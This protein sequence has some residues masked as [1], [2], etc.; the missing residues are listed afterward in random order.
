VLKVSVWRGG[1]N[2]A[3]Q[4]FEVPREASQ[5]ILDVVTHIQRAL[6]PTL[7][8]CFACRVGMCGSCAMTVNGVPRWPCRTHVDKVAEGDAFDRLVDEPAFRR[9]RL[10]ARELVPA[11]VGPGKLAFRFRPLVEERRHVGH[12]VLHDRQVVERPDLERAVLRDCGHVRAARPARL[13]VHGHRAR[14]AHADAAREAIGQRRIEPALDVRDDVEDGLAFEPGHL[15][16]LIAPRLLSAPD[17]DLQRLHFVLVPE[18]GITPI[19]TDA[20]ART[21][22]ARALPPR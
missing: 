16:L 19:R 9:L 3:F 15:E 10:D 12:E 13:A 7:A 17:A 8:Y 18:H 1:S 5:T 14:A 21:R 11:R 6:D 4:T 20:S 22:D 2:G